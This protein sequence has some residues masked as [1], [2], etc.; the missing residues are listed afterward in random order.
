MDRAMACQVLF[1]LGCRLIFSPI[2]E[3]CKSSLQLR[4]SDIGDH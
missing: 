2:E 4:K 3:V 1:V